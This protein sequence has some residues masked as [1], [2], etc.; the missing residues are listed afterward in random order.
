MARKKTKAKRIVKKKSFP[1]FKVRPDDPLDLRYTASLSEKGHCVLSTI[2]WL[3]PIAKWNSI[4][5]DASIDV[6]LAKDPFEL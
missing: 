3:Y 1:S 6:R 4:Y 5:L 2:N